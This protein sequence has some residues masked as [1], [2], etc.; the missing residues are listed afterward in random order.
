MHPV[1][2]VLLNEIHLLDMQ[3]KLHNFDF[4][5]MRSLPSA[6]PALLCEI[7]TDKALKDKM[8]RQHTRFVSGPLQSG[9]KMV[10]SG[11]AN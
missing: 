7:A 1:H 6:R 10:A 2:R 9:E 8:T 11:L 3:E 5:T 4:E